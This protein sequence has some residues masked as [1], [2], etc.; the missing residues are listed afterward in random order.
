MFWKGRE[1]RRPNQ[2]ALRSKVWVW[3]RSLA[4]IV[5]S[6]PV[7]VIG[8]LSLVSVVCC[9]RSLRRA[10][11]SSRGV[12]PSV[13]C[14]S[15]IVRPRWRGAPGPLGAVAPW[16]GGGEDGSRLQKNAIN[17]CRPAVLKMQTIIS[18]PS[19][20]VTLYPCI[21]TESNVFP[22]VMS[23]T[24]WFWNCKQLNACTS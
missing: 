11:H 10:D 14:L 16:A 6:N 7:V 15:V 4:G 22:A 5:G 18:S 20:P 3:G 19:S 8:C 1:Y 21:S 17:T 23:F 9:Q 2:V 24:V 13:V 12:L